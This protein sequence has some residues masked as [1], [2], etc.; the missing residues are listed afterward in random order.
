[1]CFDPISLGILAAGTA[2]SAGGGMMARNEALTNEQN[3]A[4]AKNAELRRTIGRQKQFGDENANVLSDAISK[5]A[6]QTQGAA[7]MAADTKR[8]NAVV[9]NMTPPQTTADAVPLGDTPAVIKNA[10]ASRIADKFAKATDEARA[11]AK[12]GSYGDVWTNNNLGITGAARNVDTTNTFARDDASLLPAK[13][14]LGAYSVWK[15]SSGIGETLQGLGNLA[16]AYG[17]RRA[18][19][20]PTP[21]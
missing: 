17:G 18:G 11:K 3:Q 2:A 7:G 9:G 20:A 21:A 6:P 10:Y 16:A 19:P 15:P 12:F 13:Q 8:E 1:M 5:F 14:D 4:L